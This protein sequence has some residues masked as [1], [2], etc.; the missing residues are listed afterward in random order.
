MSMRRSMNNYEQLESRGFTLIE[1]LVVIAIIGILSSTV[2]ASL[3]T[4]RAKARDASIKA[5]ANQLVSMMELNYQEYGDYC[6]LQDG[7]VTQDGGACNTR[8]AGT[9]APKAREIC[10][11]IHNNAYDI[12]GPAGAYRLYSGTSVGCATTYSI[13]IA[14]NT[15]KWYCVGSSGRKGEY[16]GYT[17]QPGCYNNP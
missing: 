1:L 17:G 4:A 11:N 2:L 12:W 6:H 7:W 3:N 9:Y 5:Q 8:Y 13:M 10:T 14:L 15:G 16:E